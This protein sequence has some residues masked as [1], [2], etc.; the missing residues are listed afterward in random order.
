MERETGVY[1]EIIPKDGKDLTISAGVLS[2]LP[3]GRENS[4]LTN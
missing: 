4:S 2:L 3:F 1:G